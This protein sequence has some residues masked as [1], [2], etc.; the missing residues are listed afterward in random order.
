ME[1]TDVRAEPQQP[2]FLS[3]LKMQFQVEARKIQ[4]FVANALFAL[5]SI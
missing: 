5:S 1:S 4:G 2:D 3:L